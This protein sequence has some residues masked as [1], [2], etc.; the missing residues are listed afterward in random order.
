LAIY[1]RLLPALPTSV[2]RIRHELDDA[3]RRVG[4]PE[5]KRQDIAVVV[6]EAAT[7][8]TLHAYPPGRP[9]PI[10]TRA[11]LLRER[12]MLTVSDAGHGMCA[13][14]DS[15]GLGVGLTVMRRLSHT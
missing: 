14:R 10:Y 1:A 13:R 7:N 8:A 4:M 2:A 5:H 15:P 6:S 11:T 9:G 12:L 3:L